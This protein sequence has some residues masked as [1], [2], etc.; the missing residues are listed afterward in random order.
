MSY[1]NPVP[2]FLVCVT[3]K[4][5]TSDAGLYTVNNIELRLTTKSALNLGLK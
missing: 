3:L 5:A 1:S 4:E 2:G